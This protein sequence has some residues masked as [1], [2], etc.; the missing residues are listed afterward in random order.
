MTPMKLS[1]IRRAWQAANREVIESQRL[2][3]EAK[4]EALRER[5]R[6]QGASAERPRSYRRALEWDPI[7]F[8]LGLFLGGRF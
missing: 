2:A 5:R 6:A 4:R 3:L 1:R 7:A 8:L